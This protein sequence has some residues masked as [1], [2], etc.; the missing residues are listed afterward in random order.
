MICRDGGLLPEILKGVIHAVVLERPERVSSLYFSSRRLRIGKLQPGSAFCL[1]QA[2]FQPSFDPRTP[3]TYNPLGERSGIGYNDDMQNDLFHPLTIGGR[4]LAGNIALAPMAGTSDL[5]F[6]AICARQGASFVCTELVS[7]RG[8]RF[9]GGIGKS[10]RYLEIAPDEEGP[11]A[12]Q[13]FGFD[14]KDFVEAIPH[15]LEHPVLGGAFAI[16]INMGCPVAKVVKTGAGSALMRDLKRAEAILRTAVRVAEPYG[17]PVTVKFRKGWDESLVNAPEFARMCVDAGTA[18]LT[19]HAR[20]RDQ[21]Y[22]G[23]ADWE[24]LTMAAESIRGSGIPLFGN[25]DVTDGD[26][27]A[28]MIR[29]TGVDGVM[30]GRAAQGNPWL[31]AS[32]CA[33]LKGT[34]E[35]L[36]PTPEERVAVIL[37]HLEGQIPRLGG[38]TAVREMRSQLAMYLKGQPHG[39]VY[40][41]LAMHADT[42]A[43]VREILLRWASEA[44]EGYLQTRT[45]TTN[46]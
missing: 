6:R 11:V 45:D 31:F 21:M 18:A 10:Y 17:V 14:P 16:D 15:I 19:L 4:T 42:A 37:A 36:P 29:E 5:P 7:A 33:Y 43:E 20:T 38:E 25:G 32:V 13:L 34:P 12:I 24:I 22:T 1:I 23:K 3:V 27:A 41:V 26:S 28:R 8:I 35:P 2:V 44:T 39:V 30:I 9:A 46:P 40:K